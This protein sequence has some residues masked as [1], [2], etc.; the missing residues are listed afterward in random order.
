LTA[1]PAI[2]ERGVS[3]WLMAFIALRIEK[4]TPSQGSATAFF[5]DR[6]PQGDEPF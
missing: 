3:W 6:E 1:L 4:K 5:A 2:G